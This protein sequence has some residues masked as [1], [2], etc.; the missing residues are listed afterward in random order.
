MIFWRGWWGG[1]PIKADRA[2][3]CGCTGIY[4]TLFFQCAYPPDLISSWVR[5]LLPG[6][7][8]MVEEGKTVENGVEEMYNR[9][10]LHTIFYLSTS[11]LQASRP[12]HLTDHELITFSASGR[13]S[14]ARPS[15]PDSRS[16]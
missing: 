9:V 14:S 5:E 7:E 4:R 8:L 11:T 16:L 12:F 10:T 15:A 1:S 13:H 6:A 3:A 2:A